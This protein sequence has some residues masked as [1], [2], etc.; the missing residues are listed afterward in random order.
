MVLTL[1]YDEI[2][3]A[4]NVK[5]LL[6]GDAANG[7]KPGLRTIRFFS[8]KLF[9]YLLFAFLGPYMWHMEVP[10]LGVESEL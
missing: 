4:L 7:C 10:R 9:S 1:Y 5:H 6:Q 2:T 8:K 3:E